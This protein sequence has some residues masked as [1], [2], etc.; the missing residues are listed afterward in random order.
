MTTA[1]SSSS[2]CTLDIG[3]MTCASCVRHVEKALSRIDGVDSAEV[4]LAT[5]AATVSFDPQTAGLSELTAAVTA[6]GYT[7]TPRHAAGPQPAPRDDQDAATAVDTAHDA[8]LRDLKRKWQVTLTAGLG[9]MALMY[10]PLNLDTMDWL[11]PAIFVV[12][13]VLQF[14]AGRGFYAAA[15]AAAR[16]GATNMNT[17]VALGTSVAYLYSAFVTLWPAQAQQWGL[18]LHVYFETALVIIALVLMGRWL[19]GRAKKRTSAAITALVGLAPKT[20]RVLR[21]GTEEDVPVADLRLGDLI[22]VRPGETIPVDG[23]ITE[24]SS[25]VEESMLTGEAAP[26]HKGAGDQVIGGTLNRT[27]SIIFRATAVGPDTTLAQIVRLVEEA[28]GSKVPLQRLADRVSAWFVPAVLAAAALTFAVW[29]WL[30]PTAGSTGLTMAISTAI[31]VLIVACPCALGLATPTAV[32][33]G[34]GK[35]AELG[36][37]IGDGQA[38]ETARHLTAVV[39]DKT[40]TI[41]AGRPDLVGITA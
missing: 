5:E 11:M 12:A 18:P 1:T 33:V 16:H 28:Q 41:T 35:A 13:T 17:L 6:A 30:V 4:N 24:G 26:V 32:M 37:L 36:I 7:A 10:L 15:W 8:Q 23:A 31:A 2:I 39:L 9:L 20:A 25:T 19:E 38:L 40:G 21:D 27:G 29:A 22:R 14:W 3:G 34:T